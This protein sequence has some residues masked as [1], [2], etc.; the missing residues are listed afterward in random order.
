MYVLECELLTPASL[1][2][3]FAV[4]EN[5]YNLAKITPPW[6][7]FRIVTQGL[8]MRR[9]ALIDYELRWL[10][11][12]LRWKTQ[13]TAYEPPFYFVDEALT[14]PYR[15][16]K[17]AHTFRRTEAGTVVADRVEYDLPLGLLGK[18]AHAVIVGKQLRGIF[19]F[20]Q[21]AIAELLG[22]HEVEPPAPSIRYV[23]T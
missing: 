15:F 8:E 7:G 20:R 9:G 10:G 16:W 12:P 1:E 11:L 23:K 22:G 14:S 21:R 5:P 19:G 4:F 18:A 6:M 2:D 13:I 3:T 17:H